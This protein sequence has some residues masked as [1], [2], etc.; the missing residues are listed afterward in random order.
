MV[1]DINEQGL[2]RTKVICLR[3][4]TTADVRESLA[5]LNVNNFETV[6]VHT[7]TNNCTK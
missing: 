1:R 3:G 6:V 4:G 7:G 5:D 2:E